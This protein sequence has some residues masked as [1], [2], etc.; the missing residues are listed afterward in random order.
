MS[1][2]LFP[3]QSYHAVLAA[4]TGLAGYG[5]YSW[6]TAVAGSASNDS[7]SLNI[8]KIRVAFESSTMLESEEMGQHICGR[9]KCMKPGES[10][11][12]SNPI[13]PFSWVFGSDGLFALSQCSS[14][15]QMCMRLGFE[16][17]WIELQLLK[18]RH[19]NLFLFPESSE[20]YTAVCA[21]WNG[22]FRLLEA[23]E[24][25]VYSK[26][27]AFKEDLMSTS[28]EDIESKSDFEFIDVEERGMSDD[29]YLSK[30]RF[31]QIDDEALTLVDCRFFLYCFVGLSRYYNGDGYTMEPD[32]KRGVKE[33]LIRNMK[34]DEMDG[35]KVVP[36]NVDLEP[37][38]D[39][40]T[41]TSEKM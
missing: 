25:E 26:L 20:H 21:T 31:L 24:P 39:S 13:K 27:K 12:L 1:R 9:I 11:T 17:D 5:A 30:E 35:M 40:R 15:Y 14:H 6:N 8:D 41:N 18:G 28:F 32:G 36:L 4:I 2:F 33:Y 16:R 19:F 10:T 38:S 7:V 23:E 29:R 3:S 22:V 37:T 34:L